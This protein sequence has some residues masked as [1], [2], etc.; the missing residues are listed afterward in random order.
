ML[1]EAVQQLFGNTGVRVIGDRHGE[2]LYETLLTA[3]ER[4]HCED[5][6]DY[7]RVAADIRDLIYDKYFVEGKEAP[8]ELEPYTSHN[9]RRLTVDEVVEK[10]LTLEDVRKELQD[11]GKL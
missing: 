9:T 7:F 8:V 2:K 3:E 5:L 6:G 10:L 4:A 1:A 11:L